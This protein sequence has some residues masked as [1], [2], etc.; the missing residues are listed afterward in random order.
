M[1]T[2]HQ[3]VKLFSPFLPLALLLAYGVAFGAAALGFSL[4]AFDDHPGQLYRLWHVVMRGPAPWAWNPGWWTGYPELQFYPPGFAYA[5]AA[6]HAVTLGALS[7]PATYQT[8]VWLAYLAP[9][10]T[11]WLLLRRV[12]GDGW[13]ALPGA[14]VGLTLS[15]GLGSGVEG[16]V[17]IGMVAARLGWAMLPLLPLA[18]AGWSEG[19]QNFPRSVVLLVAAVV[20]THPAHGPAAVVLVLLAAWCSAATRWAATG[21]AVAA[22]GL[23]G[24]VAAF[25]GLPL[26]AHLE[27]TRALAWGSLWGREAPLG[28]P[29]AWAL[30]VLAAAGSANWPRAR[31]SP[32]VALLRIF[33]WVM[34]V[35]VFVDAFVLE[36]LGLHWLPADRVVDSA[37]LAFVLAGGATAGRLINTAGADRPR[38]RV[39]LSLAAVVVALLLALPGRTLTLWPRASEWPRSEAIERGMRLDALWST[40]RTAPAGRV[41]FVR[42]GVPLVYGSQWWRPH[43]HVTAMTPLAAGRAIVNGTFTHP[44]PVAALL[45]RG[46]AGR[47]AIRELVEQLDGRRLFGRALDE[48]DA[49][50]FNAYADRLGVS[51]VV[52]L[53]EDVPH[54]RALRDNPLFPRATP[55]PPFVVYTRR[56]P[57]A[58]PR[59]VAPGRFQLTAEAAPDTWL[60]TRMAYYPLWHA[61]SAGGTMPTRRGD[62]GDLEVRAPGPAAVI[63]LVYKTGLAEAAGTVVSVASLSL[64]AILWT[65]ARLTPGGRSARR[66]AKKGR[67]VPPARPS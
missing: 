35:V 33:P 3:M 51:T 28:H 10:L 1:V 53:D 45:Y 24:G 58:L 65:T 4:I 50:V 48:L 44:S 40:L 20:L 37:W 22:L 64:L 49:G 8:L 14:F 31:L 36:R 60:P 12:L 29:L 38:A 2:Y 62:L 34:V 56:S 41:L 21:R 19:K 39:A 57:V 43:S 16:G 54:L 67:G 25:W 66:E 47:G 6:L 63:D 9:A 61:T 26:V 55:S 52:A 42:S 23:A 18:L 27:H 7:V 32:T 17:H 13:P 59:E 46:D 11:L 15:A 5:G 30:V